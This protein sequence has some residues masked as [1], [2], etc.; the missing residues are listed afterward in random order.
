M[1]AAAEQSKQLR[2]YCIGAGLTAILLG[3]LYLSLVWS[4]PLGQEALCL[5]GPILHSSLFFSVLVLITS[6]SSY[7]T[8]RNP[9][10]LIFLAPAITF[11]TIIFLFILAR[12]PLATYRA[13]Q[14]LAT[15]TPL[16]EAIETY[17]QENGHAPDDLHDLVPDYLAGIPT[18]PTIG[19]FDY[20]Y[21]PLRY[22]YSNDPAIHGWQN[23]AWAISL[24]IPIPVF[25][26]GQVLY[27][28]DHNYP[29]DAVL[30]GEW[31]W[32]GENFCWGEPNEVCP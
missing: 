20:G 32:L 14:L 10:A 18:K 8:R 2:T 31:A 15:F 30:Y 11:S 1:D 4:D 29:H 23:R 26:Y 17:E 24:R 28:P 9:K 6:G 22:E 3:W 16:I 7:A 13:R 21:E 19:N 5:Y 27:L 12:H 25:D